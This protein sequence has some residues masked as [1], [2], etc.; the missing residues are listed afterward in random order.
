MCEGQ[1]N[2][3]K[4]LLGAIVI[5][6][7]L[8]KSTKL[9]ICSKLIRYN[10][11]NYNVVARSFVDFYNINHGITIQDVTQPLLIHRVRTKTVEE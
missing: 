9:N 5:T 3:K 7:C 10:N 11:F 1:V 2:T 4:T 8:S 6:R